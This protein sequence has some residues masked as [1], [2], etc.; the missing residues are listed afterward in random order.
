[1]A[2]FIYLG[3]FSIWKN[4]VF[5]HINLLILLYTY[6]IE[7]MTGIYFIFWIT[8]QH[9]YSLLYCFDF[10][11]FGRGALLHANAVYELI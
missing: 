1:M 10:S 6:T 3:L 4:Y 2:V 11:N 5:F 7:Q 8:V 9:Y